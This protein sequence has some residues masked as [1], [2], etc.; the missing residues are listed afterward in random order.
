MAISAAEHGVHQQTPR[1]AEMPNALLEADAQGLTRLQTQLRLA[2]WLVNVTPKVDELVQRLQ[3]RG[4][5][6]GRDRQELH[7]LED[8]IVHGE[9]TWQRVQKAGSV[10]TIALHRANEELVIPLVTT[11]DDAEA[12]LGNTDMMN[13]YYARILRER[14]PDRDIA[15]FLRPGRLNIRHGTCAH[16]FMKKGEQRNAEGVSAVSLYGLALRYHVGSLAALGV[17]LNV[18]RAEM[19]QKALQ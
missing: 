7:H 12:L 15:G 3:G 9:R 11:V 19:L 1:L 14:E 5:A 16:P 2:S 8:G 4:R 6:L 17:D 18:S 10:A 13:A